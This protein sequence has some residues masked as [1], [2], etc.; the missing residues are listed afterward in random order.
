MTRDK[1]HYIMMTVSIH[2]EDMTIINMQAH[3]SRVSKYMK[4]EIHSNTIVGKHT[5]RSKMDKT[6]RQ[7]IKKESENLN[8][9]TDQMELTDK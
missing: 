1:E 4:G 2:Q 7:K 3:N 9:T 5:P 8:D 6:Y